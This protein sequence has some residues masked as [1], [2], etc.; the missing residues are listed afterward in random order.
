M[1]SFFC[2]FFLHQRIVEPDPFLGERKP[3]Y[4]P[5]TKMATL[6]EKEKLTMVAVAQYKMNQVFKKTLKSSEK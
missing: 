3:F 1:K 5:T 4:Y 6:A 2:G